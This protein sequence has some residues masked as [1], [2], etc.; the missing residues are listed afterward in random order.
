L[1]LESRDLVLGERG[2]GDAFDAITKFAVD[3][4]AVRANED[5]MGDIDIDGRLLA[6]IGRLFVR[7]KAHQGE[8]D[9]LLLLLQGN[10]PAMSRLAKW[11]SKSRSQKA[12]MMPGLFF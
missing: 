7:G 4:T 1:F 12:P 8:E 9:F 3:P 6:T 11:L 10:R 5:A 2:H